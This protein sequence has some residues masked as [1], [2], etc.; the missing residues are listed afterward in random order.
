MTM[1]YKHVKIQYH[2]Y[3]GGK[4]FL[5]LTDGDWGE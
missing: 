5:V 1:D 4:H 3:V 2:D